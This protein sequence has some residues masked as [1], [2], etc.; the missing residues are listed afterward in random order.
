MHQDHAN[1]MGKEA[2]SV[3][4]GNQKPGYCKKEYVMSMI[5]QLA[6]FVVG[7]KY[8]FFWG[9]L[10]ALWLWGTIL[11]QFLALGFYH[12]ALRDLGLALGA[13]ALMRLSHRTHNTHNNVLAAAYAVAKRR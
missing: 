13:L 12:I 3:K 6:A 8:K 2:E 4:T 1:A 9:Y 5:H 10:I 11:N 7:A